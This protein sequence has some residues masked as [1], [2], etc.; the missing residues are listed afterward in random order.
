MPHWGRRAQIEDYVGQMRVTVS[1]I[2]RV[3][4]AFAVL[5]PAGVSLLLRL[6]RDG[7]A[8]SFQMAMVLALTLLVVPIILWEMLLSLFGF[9]TIE[10]SHGVLTREFHLFGLA[11]SRMW[12]AAGITGLCVS[13]WPPPGVPLYRWIRRPLILMRYGGRDFHLIRTDLPVD[14]AADICARLGDALGMTDPRMVPEKDELLPALPLT[15]PDSTDKPAGL[16]VLILGL[17]ACLFFGVVGFVTAAGSPDLLVPVG[18]AFL[19][20]LVLAVIGW[21][22]VYARGQSGGE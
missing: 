4:V 2:D 22:M 15:T 14:Q 1:G 6:S 3:V 7:H 16:A 20:S 10:L 18:F 13:E 17:G 8:A 19:C 11:Y 21:R 12:P 9:M 5:I